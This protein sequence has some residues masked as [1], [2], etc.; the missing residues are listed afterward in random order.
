MAMGAC[1]RASRNTDDSKEGSN[2]KAGR[3]QGSAG[4]SVKRERVANACT[5]ICSVSVRAF[6]A[7]TQTPVWKRPVC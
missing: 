6:D 5:K 3:G 1:T 7:L 2:G 4:L